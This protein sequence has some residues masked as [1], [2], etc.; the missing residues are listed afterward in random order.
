MVRLF[1]SG[2]EEVK[3]EIGVASEEVKN[4]F[5]LGLNLIVAFTGDETL[6]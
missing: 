4:C 5:H 2:S 3:R 6:I 1:K